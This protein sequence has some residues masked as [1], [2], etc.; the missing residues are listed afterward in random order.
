[1]R[2]ENIS[3]GGRKNMSK[4]LQIES[5]SASVTYKPIGEASAS[6]ATIFSESN[7][8]PDIYYYEV[9][10]NRLYS[11]MYKKYLD[12]LYTDAKNQIVIQKM[13][14]WSSANKEGMAVWISPPDNKNLSCKIT[15]STIWKGRNLNL[16]KNVARVV[17]L[18]NT[19]MLEFANLLTTYSV[20]PLDEISTPDDLVVKLI[21]IKDTEGTLKMIEKFTSQPEDWSKYKNTLKNAATLV[22]NYKKSKNRTVFNSK[23]RLNMGNYKL[24]CD[25]KTGTSEQ[26]AS[27]DKYGS[28]IVECPTCHRK[29]IRPF[30]QLIRRCKYCGS[31]AISCGHKH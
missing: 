9:R 11:L 22:K 26:T 2:S 14:E 17:D 21:I 30:N 8:K 18:D 15:I 24:S 20:D 5:I 1:V 16:I 19:Q 28:L 12:E 23:I 29:N 27:V 25:L 3:L 10:G 13:Q 4:E 6:V 31:D 7:R